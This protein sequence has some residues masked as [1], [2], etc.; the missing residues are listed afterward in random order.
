MAND[1]IVVESG[2]IECEHGGKVIL[3]STVPNHLINGKKPLFDI[4]ILGAEITGCPHLAP[5]GG[6]CTKVS[7]IS[8]AVTESNVGNAGTNYLLRV[9]GCQTDKGAALVLVDPGQTNTHVST[10]PSASSDTPTQKALEK[11]KLNTKENLKKEKYRIYPLRRSGKK[12]RALRGAR[13]FQLL[14]NYYGSDKSGY[15]ADKVVTFTD[16]YLYVKHNGK[17]QEYKVLN[18]G[19]MINPTIDKVHFMDTKTNIVRKYIPFYE[20]SGSVELVYSNIKLTDAEFS[21]FDSGKLN[22]GDKKADYVLHPN[23]YAKNVKHD[24]KEFKKTKLVSKDEAKKAKKRYMNILV[25]IP[26]PLGEVEDLKNEMESSYYRAYAHN[27]PFFQK[28]KE[29]NAYGYRVASFMDDLYLSKSEKKEREKLKVIIQESYNILVD[30]LQNEYLEYVI[31][32]TKNLKPAQLQPEPVR[33][34]RFIEYDLSMNYLQEVKGSASF[35]LKAQPYAGSHYHIKE[36]NRLQG[37]FVKKAGEWCIYTGKHLGLTGKY[38]D[39]NAHYLCLGKNAYKY[40]KKSDSLQLLKK[41]SYPKSMRKNTIEFTALTLFTLYFSDTHKEH[42]S[43]KYKKVAE[44]FYFALKGL[45]TRPEFNDKRQRDINNS[46]ESSL[47]RPLLRD[48]KKEPSNSFIPDYENLLLTAKEFAFTW[49]SDKAAPKELKTLIPKD[50]KFEFYHQKSLNSPQ[51][52][53][54]PL[55]KELIKSKELKSII[56]KY[57]DILEDR[58]SSMSDDLILLNMAYMLINNVTHLDEVSNVTSPFNKNAPTLEL[59]KLLVKRLAKVDEELYEKYYDEDIFRRY[60][61]ML[62]TFVSHAL[63]EGANNKAGFSQRSSNAKSFLDGV[64]QTTP[65]VQTELSNVDDTNINPDLKVKTETQKLLEQLKAIDGITSKITDA[66]DAARKEDEQAKKGTAKIPKDSGLT[67][68]NDTKTSSEKNKELLKAIRKTPYYKTTI[69]SLKGL[70]FFVTLFTTQEAY[71]KFNKNSLKSV[72]DLS[73]GIN[74][75][76]STLTKSSTEV[77]SPNNKA[78][79]FAKHLFGEESIPQQ[80]LAKLAIPIVIINSYY[81]IEALDNED[82]DAMIMI[83][84]KTAMVIAIGIVASFGVAAIAYITIELSWYLLS[85][86]FIDSPVEVMIE[87]SLFYQGARRSYLMESLSKSEGRYATLRGHREVWMN[88]KDIRTLGEFTNTRDFIYKNYEAHKE[89]ILAAELYEFSSYNQ[90]LQDISVKVV[91]K[92]Q[93]ENLAPKID[94]NRSGYIAVN[95]RY[96]NET[97]SGIIYFIKNSNY[98]DPIMLDVSDAKEENGAMLIDVFTPFKEEKHITIE[99]LLKYLKNNY[100]ILIDAKGSSQKFKLDIHYHKQQ[101]ELFSVA[102]I[103]FYLDGLTTEPLTPQDIKLI[104]A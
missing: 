75:I 68:D 77:L 76:A 37:S 55:E 26:D 92:S 65:K 78:L 15:S 82:Y 39:K 64:K 4:D 72:M 28:V 74:S 80:I 61:T 57:V 70:S 40:N 38:K 96:Y 97:M 27:Y 59:V 22:I 85:H 104:Q 30:G 95:K 48:G 36:Y 32:F 44:A 25:D 100:S 69:S 91:K 8:S 62:Y 51:K 1:L 47:Y 94:L 52:L 54:K 73:L 18:R 33:L 93:Y 90:T 83:T 31:D 43:A 88:A 14:K 2:K 5:V 99:Q 35:L 66:E 6:N 9:D 60:H 89:A 7:S 34:N 71:T 101:A 10:P 98:S 11:A 46:L 3:N 21:K 67:V 23:V 12:V 42:I 17:I 79:E 29:R 102:K 56:N 49:P 81:E 86:Y 63:V 24:E 84:A 58:P 87:K 20:E 45:Q 41:S 19:D 16:A 50:E 53:L 13:D 103:D